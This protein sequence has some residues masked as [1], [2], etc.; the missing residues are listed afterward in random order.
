[1]KPYLLLLYVM[2]SDTLYT[3]LFCFIFFEI[4]GHDALSLFHR[5][6]S[7]SRLAFWKCTA[8]TSLCP[9]QAYAG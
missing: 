9:V 6:T 4:P 5:P 1:M 7:G 2:H 8:H 3:I